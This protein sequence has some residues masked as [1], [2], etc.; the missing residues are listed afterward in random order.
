VS[1]DL[2][3]KKNQLITSKYHLTLI[4]AKFISYMSSQINK[5]DDDFLTY[6]LKLNETLQLLGIDD[7]NYLK[8][9]KALR[10]LL[11][12]YFIIEDDKSIIEETTFLS[13][14][15]MT[16]SENS[17]QMRFDKS[18]KPFLLQLKANFTKLSLAKIL[19]FN[20]SYTIRFYEILE[21]RATQYETYK[22]KNL[23]LFEYDLE[24]LK[25][26]L[27]GEYNEE[28]EEIE[29]KKSYKLYANF[30][31]KV[32]DVAYKELKEKGDYYFEYEPIK[33]GRAYSSI[34]FTI[35]K[36][37]EKIKKDFHQK[38]KA[39]LQKSTIKALAKE[40]IRRII[41]RQG[42]NIKD[43]LKYEQKLFQLYLKGELNFDKDIQ[44]VIQNMGVE[45]C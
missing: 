31:N 4:Q 37:G 18:L 27:V 16:K 21:F 12:T 34:K 3:V 45:F 39:M 14:F 38:R 24:E 43:K 32:L 44:E 25:E 9:R 42:D 22:N 20:S 15:K 35:F 6:D 26:M 40:Q 8:I 11:T 13:Y 29:I 41:E 7:R 36:N 23:L 28:T 30:K 10:R 33:K 5:D 19:K 2:I 1:N 17:L